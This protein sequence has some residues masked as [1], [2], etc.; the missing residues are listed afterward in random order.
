M[1]DV[2]DIVDHLLDC[3]Y[4]Q[5]FY[6]VDEPINSISDFI[7]FCPS[8]ARLMDHLTGIVYDQSGLGAYNEMVELIMKKYGIDLKLQYP[9]EYTPPH[10][11]EQ[12]RQQIEYESYCMIHR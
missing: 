11:L 9:T 1:A 7:L 4:Q 10:R 5:I 3:L 8:F 2:E 6:Q 12:L